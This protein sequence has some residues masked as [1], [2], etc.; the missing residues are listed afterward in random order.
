MRQYLELVERALEQGAER[1]DRTGT[2]PAFGHQMCFDL[3]AGFP[4]LPTWKLHIR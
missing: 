4:L 2:P 3:A 1:M